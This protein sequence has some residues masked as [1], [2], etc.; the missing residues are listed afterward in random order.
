MKCFLGGPRGSPSLYWLFEP[1]FF[2]FRICDLRSSLWS[3][4]SFLDAV[5]SGVIFVPGLD[6][7]ISWFFEFFCNCR[8]LEGFRISQFV[9]IFILVPSISLFS[10]LPV[11]IPSGVGPHSYRHGRVLHDDWIASPVSVLSILLW[12]FWFFHI[13]CF[14]WFDFAPLYLIRWVSEW[15]Y[16]G[17]LCS[18]STL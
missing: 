14:S 8:V 2:S 12:S 18:A 1:L 5:R 4:R 6:H 16:G 7:S 13:Y 11:Q 10:F 3:I 17:W 9:F 15:R